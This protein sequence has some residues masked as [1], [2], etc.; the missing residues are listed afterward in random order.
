MDTVAKI[1]QNAFKT[2]DKSKSGKLSAKE[3]SNWLHRNPQIMDNVFGWQCP[4]P[5]LGKWTNETGQESSNALQ[6]LFNGETASSGDAFFNALANK[7]DKNSG[8]K[9]QK[10]STSS[11]S[12]PL[13]P[14]HEDETTD[15]FVSQ[16]ENLST[17][18]SENKDVN[19]P[20]SVITKPRISES[21]EPFIELY[22]YYSSMWLPSKETISVLEGIRSGT[23]NPENMELHPIK[24]PSV[25]FTAPQNDPVKELLLK[26]PGDSK[27]APRTVLTED[28]VPTDTSGLKQLLKAE[29][30]RSALNLTVKLLE[31]NSK[32]VFTYSQKIMEIWF[33]R[34]ALLYELKMYS[35]ADIELEAFGNFDSAM[36]FYEY[37]PQIYSTKQ[38]SMVPFCFRI[39]AAIL[40]Q[41]LERPKEALDKLFHVHNVCLH[42]LSDLSSRSCDSNSEE[43]K[44]LQK[45]RD[46]WKERLL[47]VLYCIGNTF[48][49]QKEYGLAV[50]IFKQIAERDPR[51]VRAVLSGL[52]RISLQSG[53]IESAQEYFKRVEETG[54]DN[55]DVAK[56]EVHVNRGLL[57][58]TLDAYEESYKHFIAA[59]NLCPSNVVAINNAAVSLL[60]QG[61]RKE[62]LQ[63]LEGVVFENPEKHLLKGILFNI[64]K[65]Y[66]LENSRNLHQK[67]KLLELI[68]QHRGDG[69]DVS[70]LN[71][72]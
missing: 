8:E 11:T 23:L 48:L 30:W 62:A 53:D 29:C 39:L 70:C 37:Y 58:L 65:M 10:K 31:E 41:Y 47:K 4:K 35:A 18:A 45:G 6:D 46:L 13:S 25:Q 32:D 7:I 3:F 14:K 34:I 60:F 16:H 66:D 12:A 17:T 49:S 54:P 64:G 67:Q 56:S 61:R 15:P 69:F 36:F 44:S 1:V 55:D 52:G 68:G 33:C 28:M 38:G 72:P 51:N 21:E 63:L 24:V 19:T 26:Y 40:P 59:K 20:S 71:F 57:A 27:A 9:D 50:S 5:E 2:S 22:D 43:G 42:V